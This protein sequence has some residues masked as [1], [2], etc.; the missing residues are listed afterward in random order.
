MIRV[1]DKSVADKIAAGEVID[2]PVSIVKELVENSLDAGASSITVELKKGGKEYIRITDDGCGIDP[3]ETELAFRR[4]ATSKI[5]REEDLDSIRSLG[6]RGEA[7]ASICAVARVDMITKTEEAHAGRHVIC[8]GSEILCNSQTGC[9]E[10]T[11]I[12]VRDLFYNV[13]ARKKFLGTD[14]AES[15]RIIDLM[16]RIALAYPD[17]RF[18]VINGQKEAFSTTGRGSIL[19]NICRIYGR[20]IG[21]DLVPVDYSRDD[22]LLRGFVSSPGV[23]TS[24]RNR[25]FFCVNGR[26][27]SS[28]TVEQGLEKSYRERLFPGRFPMAFLFLQVP[29]DQLDVNVHPT[30]KEIRFDDPFAV[31][32]FVSYAVEAALT[33]RQA[34]PAVD[35]DRA[36]EVRPAE[37]SEPAESAPEEHAAPAA[38]H[39]TTSAETPM[40]SGEQVDIKNLLESMRQDSVLREPDRP[41]APMISDPIRE[42][43]EEQADTLDISSLDIIGSVFNTYVITTDGECVYLIDQHAAHERIFYEKLLRQ[44]HSSD[45]LQQEMLIPLQISVSADL[46]SIEDSWIGYLRDMGYDIENFG[47]RMYIVRAVPA[48]ADPEETERFLRQMLLELEQG[49]KIHSFAGLDRLIMRSCKSAIKGGDVMHPSE[50]RALLTQLAACDRPWSCPHGRPTIVK[51]TRYD[52]ERMFKR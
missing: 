46:E 5:E 15:R 1:L 26:V 38:E 11:T 16:S 25:Q 33:Q 10:G 52:L 48:F 6:F 37:T 49:P 7:L 23:S 34:I 27:V 8:E 39:R 19:D 32:D 43:M 13:P 29:A 42:E 47:G 21:R 35:T 40:P 45:K 44:Y 20:D 4:H 22:Y 18:R 2:R 28:K 30:K 17:V 31:E 9:P 36:K 41:D 14:G 24:S 51:L 50:L 3:D 12:T